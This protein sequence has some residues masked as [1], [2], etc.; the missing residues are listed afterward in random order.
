MADG[1]KVD[2]DSAAL[3]SALR[4]F[5]GILQP[6]VMASCKV[7]ANSILREA[8]SRIRRRSGK[9]AGGMRVDETYNGDGYVV[10]MGDAVAPD[11]TRRRESVGGSKRW[12]R[13]GA[14]QE[15]H[16]GIYLEFGTKSMAMRPFLFASGDLEVGAHRRRVEQAI[17]D[18][19]R[20]E[21]LG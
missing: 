1:L 4:D 17:I 16:V 2:V 14:Y 12:V 13:S 20:A 11:E 8:R 9:T 21:G 7:S 5:P 10:V 3:I 19:M 18:G 15:A 6:R